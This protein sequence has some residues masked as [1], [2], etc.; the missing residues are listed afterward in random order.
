MGIVNVTPDSFSDGGRFF[1]TD[2]A[3]GHALELAAAGAVA[4]DVGG[5]STRPGA[6]P[7][8]VAE[9]LRRIV[10]VIGELAA[11]VGAGVAI[12][13]DTTKPEVA[14]AA[15]A[16]GATIVNDVTGGR[17][18]EL[19][20]TVADHDAGVVLMHMQ[21]EPRTMQLAPHYDDVVV[22]VGD[23]LA[24]RVDA[25]V[26]A[27]IARDAIVAD[28]G[29]G[30]GK[31]AHHNRVL[32]AH[33]GELAERAGVPLLVGV[34]RKRMLVDIVGEDLDARDDATL[35]T[36]VLAFVQGAAIVRVHDVSRSVAAAAWLDTI[37][38]NGKEAA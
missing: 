11:A 34:S 37:A 32:L 22:E 23:Y 38:T 33:L 16:A 21:G 12:S 9:E 35:A 20:A 29:I 5:E 30:F 1:A 24:A 7:V 25:A 18:P 17:D 15:L 10:P 8:D 4:L 28:P 26:V 14:R 2:A 3:V 19:L 31:T 6:D 13:V 27:G 36:T